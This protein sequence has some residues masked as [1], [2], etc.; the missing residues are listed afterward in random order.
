[1]SEVAAMKANIDEL[2]DEV[3]ALKET[4]ARLCKQL[5]VE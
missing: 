5:G 1:V 2:Q 4:V 3:A